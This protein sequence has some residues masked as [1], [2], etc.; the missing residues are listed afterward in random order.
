VLALVTA[1]AG[2]ATIYVPEGG[3]QTIQQAVDN[4]TEGD[5]IVV[6]AAYTGTKENVD[7]NLPRLTIRSETGYVTVEAADPSDHVFHVKADYTKITGFTV[8]GTYDAEYSY[9]AGIYLDQVNHCEIS[10]NSA[11]NNFYG[12]YLY[13]STDNTISGNGASSNANGIYLSRSGTNTISGNSAHSNNNYGIYLYAS[14]DNIVSDNSA[15]SNKNSGITLLSSNNNSFSGNS[16]NFNIVYGIS[17]SSSNGSSFSGNSAVSNEKCGIALFSSNDNFFSGNAALSNNLSG[18]Y[19]YRSNKNTFSANS[20]NSNQNSG[21]DLSSS[22]ENT[23]SKNSADSNIN[24][25]IYLYF[26]NEN[27]IS[28]NAADSNKNT[29]I[30]L[31]SSGNNMISENI[32]SG[33]SQGIFLDNSNTNMIAGNKASN[34]YYG[35]SLDSSTENTIA[36]NTANSNTYYGIFL[37]ASGNTIYNNYFDNTQNAWQWSSGANSWNISKTQESN[38]IGGPYL[39]GN[40]WTDYAGI[41]N[42]NDGL[43]DTLVPYTASGN[44]PDGGD[45]LPLVLDTTPLTLTDVAVTSMTSDSATISWTT[46]EPSDSLVRYGTESGSYLL[47]VS[48]AITVISHSLTITGLA[49]ETTYY[50]VVASTDQNGN[51]VENDEGK[52]TT[53]AAAKA[54][55][56]AQVVIKPKTLNLNWNGK[57]FAFI[58]L[59]NNYMAA[60]VDINTVECGG[61]PAIKGWVARNNK[62]IVA[63]FARKDLVGVEPGSEVKLTL[64]GKL[65]DTTPFEGSDTIRVIGREDTT[66]VVIMPAV[67]NLKDKGK[68]T[69]MITLPYGYRAADVDLST[70]VCEGAPAVKGRVAHNNRYTA[71]F[72]IEAL[73]GIEPGSKVELT[74]SGNLDD[75]TPF[76]GSDTIRVIEKDIRRR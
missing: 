29:G 31:E 44:I 37:E 34:N 30:Y 60:D 6:R 56:P 8:T 39:G 23:I 48:D 55:I 45:W 64:T 43:G 20:A 51:S 59:P 21:I 12:I 46:D 68:M 15:N 27:T 13:A 71:T 54:I 63:I 75:G 61:A 38:I 7:I 35:M 58:T 49:A 57:F 41:D 73:G 11:N 18:I 26:S 76:E 22:Y 52:F 14:S 32:A 5:E 50:Y 42:D 70:V 36:G 4:A 47:T 17:L 69:A 67:L 66:K 72:E 16:A 2:A 33:S 62:Y 65:K 3:N 74:V 1:I 25:G 28:G 19:L 10:N 9:P 53:G 24:F 40:Y